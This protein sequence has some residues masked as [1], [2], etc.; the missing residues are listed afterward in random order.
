MQ[1]LAWF[2]AF[3]AKRG[4]LL[5]CLRTRKEGPPQGSGSTR[6]TENGKDNSALGNAGRLCPPIFWPVPFRP[7]DCLSRLPA[8]QSPLAPLYTRRATLKSRHESGR[9][10]ASP[11]VKREVRREFPPQKRHRAELGGNDYRPAPCELSAGTAR[12]RFKRNSCFF[13]FPWV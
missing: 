6:S 12:L 4:V 9:L 10:I 1:T 13:P 3:G 11:T 5:S 8:A 2:V 7:T